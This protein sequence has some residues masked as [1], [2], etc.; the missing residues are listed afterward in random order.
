MR[1][2]RLADWGLLAQ[3]QHGNFATDVL[4]LDGGDYLSCSYDGRIARHRGAPAAPA[5]TQGTA[6]AGEPVHAG[7]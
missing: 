6:L 4:A 5:T 2:W 7:H 3:S 1:V